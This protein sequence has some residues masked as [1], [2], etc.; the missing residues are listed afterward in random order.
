[1]PRDP[2]AKAPASRAPVKSRAEHFTYAAPKPF[3]AALGRIASE[4][5]SGHRALAAA[6][7]DGT[8]EGFLDFGLCARCMVEAIPDPVKRRRFVRAHFAEAQA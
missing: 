1:M 4:R 8:E 3:E 5:D 7:L 2:E 6:L